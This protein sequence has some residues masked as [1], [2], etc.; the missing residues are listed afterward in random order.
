MNWSEASLHTHTQHTHT[1]THTR[2]STYKHTLALVQKELAVFEN[3]PED[4]SPG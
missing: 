2:M 4:L 3:L 1:H